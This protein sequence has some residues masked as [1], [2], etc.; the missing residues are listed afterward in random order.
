MSDTVVEFAMH[1]GTVTIKG[2][3]E[4]LTALQNLIEVAIEHEASEASL[5]GDDG[6]GYVR[7]YSHG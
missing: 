2:S 6:V 5:L 4:G 3:E 7:V 1:D